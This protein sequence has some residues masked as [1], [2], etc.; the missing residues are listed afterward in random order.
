MLGGPVQVAYAVD[1]LRIAVDGWIAD[2]V[3]PFFVREHIPVQRAR[4][5]GR[6]DDF[7]HSSAFA[8]WGAVMVELIQQHDGGADPV[9]G[10]S[11]LHHVA[12][13][14]DDFGAA[15]VELT[16]NG[17]PELLY[18]ETAN[19]MPFAF[20]DARADRGHHIE[21]YERVEPLAR[22]YDMVRD[23]SVDWDGSD[24]IRVL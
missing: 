8:Q 3:G 19:G 17:W 2:G 23:S 4:V 22:F 9:V 13:F 18:A 6:P 5:R 14:V 10:A 15:S 11:G 7:D 20:H 16:G 12:F 1:D 24:A 21:I